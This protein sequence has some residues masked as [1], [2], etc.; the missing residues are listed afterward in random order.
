M[1]LAVVLVAEFKKEAEDIVVE[2]L[3]NG[4][5]R[6]RVFSAFVEE[7]SFVSDRIAGHAGVEDFAVRV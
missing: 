7:R 6:L 5:V 3:E 4:N 1:A 2:N